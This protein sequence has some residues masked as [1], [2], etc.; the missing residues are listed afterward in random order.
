MTER[1][2]STSR[3]KVLPHIIQVSAGISNEAAGTTYCIRRLSENLASAGAS[4]QV[5]A[6]GEGAAPQMGKADAYLFP[7]ERALPGLGTLLF[8]RALRAHLDQAAA[9]PGTVIHCNGLWRMPNVYP[10]EAAR[11]HGAPL[12]VSPHG[13]LAEDALKFSSAQKRVFG[14]LAQDR[15]LATASCIHATSEK[16]LEDVRAYG[17]K[18]PVAL[19]PIGIDIPKLPPKRYDTRSQREVLYLGRLH[20]IKGIDRLLVAWSR[21]EAGHPDWRVRIVGPSEAGCIDQL[22]ALASKLGLARVE[23]QPGLFGAEKDAAYGD[24]DVFVLPSLNENFGMVVAEALACETP[25]IC[26]KGAPWSGLESHGC[27]W[28]VDHGADALEAAL[29][30]ALAMPREA[31]AAMGARGRAWV[32]EAFSWQPIADDMLAVYRWCLGA[33]ERPACVVTD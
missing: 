14:L 2:P 27:G 7:A 28:W 5:A 32:E 20:P 1:A 24:A 6:I 30:A 26:S 18:A 31:L 3:T 9:T 13:M 10:G 16:E 8:S 22:K 29:R 25:V 4:V 19:I 33:G 17:L 11:R 12:V 23:F 15:A 21:L